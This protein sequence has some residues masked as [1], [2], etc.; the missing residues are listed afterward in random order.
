[1]SPN[2]HFSCDRPLGTLTEDTV[3]SPAWNV[4]SGHSADLRRLSHQPG[5][6][7]QPL[8][9]T[10]VP[11]G[12]PGTDVTCDGQASSESQ[13]PS[14]F[15]KT[16]TRLNQGS[17][18]C[19]SPLDQLTALD[20]LLHLLVSRDSSTT[21]V[22]VRPHQL[23]VWFFLMCNLLHLALT[24]GLHHA[25]L[26][27]ILP[28]A[29]SHQ[30]PFQ[31]LLFP[32]HVQNSSGPPPTPRAGE[33]SPAPISRSPRVNFLATSTDDAS[34]RQGLRSSDTG[35]MPVSLWCQSPPPVPESLLPLFCSQPT[36]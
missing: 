36:H 22:H 4:C 12:P 25:L 31:P 32:T 24:R 26:D 21:R 13:Q 5:L 11:A 34:N 7:G 30:S 33:C 10:F 17:N 8:R 1:M 35:G 2:K 23:A 19:T 9:Q 15:T 6:H 29:S 18:T 16:L 27:L 20:H 28:C 3:P 14:N